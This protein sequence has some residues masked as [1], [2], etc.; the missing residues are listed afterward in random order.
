MRGGYKHPEEWFGPLPGLRDGHVLA[1]EFALP[2][3]YVPWPDR[4]PLERVFVLLDLGVSLVQPYWQYV[5]Q[6]DGSRV[7]GVDHDSLG[8]RSWYVDLVEVVGGPDEYRIRDLFADV[9]VASDGRGHRMLDLEELADALADG[10]LQDPRSW[11][12]CAVG[13]RSSTGTSISPAIPGRV[14]AISRRRA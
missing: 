11:T 3:Q 7:G 9:I 4:E 2:P 8:D 13:R 10:V 5:L 14:G 1:Y 12:A 6:P